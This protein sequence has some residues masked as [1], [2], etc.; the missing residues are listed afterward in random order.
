[1]CN[2]LIKLRIKH[3]TGTII[4]L[5]FPSDVSVSA[6]TKNEG[7][8]HI[9]D[10]TIWRE[11]VFLCR[12]EINFHLPWGKFLLRLHEDNHPGKEGQIWMCLATKLLFNLKLKCVVKFMHSLCHVINIRAYSQNL[13]QLAGMLRLRIWT[14]NASPCWDPG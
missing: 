2:L 14:Q 5:S 1:M 7:E 13:T 8:R 11:S 9:K 10:L 12:D 3:G 6:T 4:K